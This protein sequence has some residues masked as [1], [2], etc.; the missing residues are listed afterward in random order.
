MKRRNAIMSNHSINSLDFGGNSIRQDAQGFV[1]L[2]DMWKASGESDKRNPKSFLNLEQTKALFAADKKG[3]LEGGGFRGLKVRT[4][5]GRHGGTWGTRELAVAYAKYLSPQFH[6]WALKVIVERIE[7]EVDPELGIK[8]ATDRAQKRW[9]A[10]GHTDQWIA[11]RLRGIHVRNELTSL[12]Q[13]R[14]FKFAQHFANV[15]NAMY[16]GL[17]GKDAGDLR[18][19]R[20]LN[21]KANVRDAMNTNEILAVAL[22]ENLTRTRAEDMRLW[23]AS[24]ICDAANHCGK[25]VAT[26][27]HN[28]LSQVA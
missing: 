7:E 25:Q 4:T 21:E 23:G 19:E 8:R 9:K 22:A 14:G 27:V 12:C 3:A 24:D 28:A 11:T 17:L 6:L 2:T 26:A 20:G 18:Q 16:I 10:M 15:T 5:V 1:C 13:S